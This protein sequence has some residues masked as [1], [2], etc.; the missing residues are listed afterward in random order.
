[1][2]ASGIVE[3][4]LHI[5]QP[6]LP[7]YKVLWAGAVGQAV[8]GQQVKLDLGWPWGSTGGGVAASLRSR[9]QRRQAVAAALGTTGLQEGTRRYAH[10]PMSRL[11]SAFA[12]SQ[13]GWCKRV[14]RP[15]EYR[16]QSGSLA[17]RAEVACGFGLGGGLRLSGQGPGRGGTTCV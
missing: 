11:Y 2:L 13:A 3:V 16:C 12:F 10:R 17:R 4:R 7:R 6:Y 5:S 15:E 9:T 8:R 14:G 1:M